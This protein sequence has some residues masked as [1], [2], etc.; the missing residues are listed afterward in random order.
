[1]GYNLPSLREATCIVPGQLYD[2][3]GRVVRAV[4]SKPIDNEVGSK[5]QKDVPDHCLQCDLYNKHIPCSFNHQMANG[6]DICENHHLK[7]SASTLA[8]F[9]DYHYGKA[10]P[11]YK[12]DK[13]TGHLLEIPSKKQ[14]REN[15]KKI[16]EQKGK[17]QLP[18]SP[19]T[20]HETQAEKNFKRS[21]R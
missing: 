3:F 14:V 16:R 13:K 12:L 2:H 15:V 7:S 18:K 6:N 17:D 1:M 20:I 11:R 8:T 4:P 19:V 5:E 21:R 10:K 9:K